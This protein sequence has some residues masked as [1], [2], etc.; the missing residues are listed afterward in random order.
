MSLEKIDDPRDIRHWMGHMECDYSYTYGVAGEK[1]FKEI[2][3]NA[4]IMGTKCRNCGLTYVPPRLFCERCFERLQEWVEVG[5]KGKIH[6]YTIAYIDIDGN[7][8]KK[9][10]IWAMVKIDNVHGGFVHK[11]GEV[12]SKDVKIGMHVKAVFKEKKKRVGS[13]LDIKY[14][15]PEK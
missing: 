1:F 14:F 7:K 6:T 13:I 15:K 10:T 2:K 8:L 12:D 3:E 11:L 9:P 5:K 4:R